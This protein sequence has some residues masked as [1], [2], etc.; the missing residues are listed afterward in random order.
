M[1]VHKYTHTIT[2][3]QCHSSLETKP[4]RFFMHYPLHIVSSATG[5]CQLKWIHFAHCASTDTEWTHRKDGE[6]GLTEE[7]KGEESINGERNGFMACHHE[8]EW[9][10]P[11]L[12]RLSVCTTEAALSVCCGVSHIFTVMTAKLEMAP[13]G[14]VM[15]TSDLH[16]ASTTNLF[17]MDINISTKR[18][19]LQFQWKL[20]TH[21][22]HWHFQ[23]WSLSVLR[24]PP[25]FQSFS[26]AHCT[27]MKHK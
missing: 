18:A 23:A 9:K 22:R 3:L 20:R 16:P 8:C 17:S 26:L 12:F 7:W 10:R 15:A 13:V 5:T 25:E 1:C 4:C 11:Q 2:V 27:W 21:W 6:G 14:I 19:T 24:I